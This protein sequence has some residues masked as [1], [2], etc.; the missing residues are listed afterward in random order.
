[1][2][3]GWHADARDQQTLHRPTEQPRDPGV[4]EGHPGGA[5]SKRRCRE[6]QAAVYE[7]GFELR[8]AIATIVVVAGING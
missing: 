4:E 7:S 2:A 1:V 3:V 5:D 6:I 8:V